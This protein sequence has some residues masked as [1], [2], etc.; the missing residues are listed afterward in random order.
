MM[1]AQTILFRSAACEFHDDQLRSNIQM[2]QSPGKSEHPTTK[3]I[4]K[5]VLLAQL[6][7]IFFSDTC[8]TS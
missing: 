5:E 2:F 6:L 4:L 3:P 1:H 7:M 8:P